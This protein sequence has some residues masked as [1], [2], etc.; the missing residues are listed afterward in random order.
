LAQALSAAFQDGPCSC[1]RIRGVI[2]YVGER[3][4]ML[5]SGSGQNGAPWVCMHREYARYGWR[6]D[7]DDVPAAPAPLLLPPPHA[8][9]SRAIPAR[10][11]TTTAWSRARIAGLGRGLELR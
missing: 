2:V 1:A 10:T 4:V 7:A 8:A 3:L 9:A 5:A 11:A 6:I